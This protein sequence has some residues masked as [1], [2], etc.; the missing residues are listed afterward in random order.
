MM[1]EDKHN[2]SP[3]MCGHLIMQED[4]LNVSFVGVAS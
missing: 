3:C 1:H 2:V 4:K